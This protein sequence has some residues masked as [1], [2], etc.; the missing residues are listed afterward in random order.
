[1]M[2]CEIVVKSVLPAMRAL[3]AK[4]LV[5]THGLK[6]VEVAEIMG[7]TQAAISQYIRGERGAVLDLS[8]PKMNKMVS[9]IAVQLK[10][11]DSSG[12]AI[13]ANFCAACQ[14]IREKKLMCDLHKQLDPFIAEEDCKFCLAKP[15]EKNLE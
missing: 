8:S 2:P 7:I 3:I 6:Q 13:I 5:E 11:R 9:N 14:L 15:E 4:E 10:N 1:M 12:E